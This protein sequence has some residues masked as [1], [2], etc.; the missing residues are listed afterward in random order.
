MTTKH[1]ITKQE[2]SSQKILLGGAFRWRC[3]CGKT[4]AW[5]PSAERR[6]LAAVKHLAAH[7]ADYD[8][9][10]VA[11]LRETAR[12]K[13]YSSITRLDRKADLVRAMRRMDELNAE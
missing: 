1:M 4:S 10:T 8:S 3:T 13:G 7:P 9:M 2:D 6:D 11:E 5:F 12:A